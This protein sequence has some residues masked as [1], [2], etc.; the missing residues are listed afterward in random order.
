MGWEG[1]IT[2]P[3]ALRGDV[4]ERAYTPAYAPAARQ[5]AAPLP[6]KLHG[7]HGVI[8]VKILVF[9]EQAHAAHWLF[10]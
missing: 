4:I 7:P 3:S 8:A 6:L 5:P 10:R 2:M 1:S 9:V